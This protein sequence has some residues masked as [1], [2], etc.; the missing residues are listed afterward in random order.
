MADDEPS[1][2]AAG[3][4]PVEGHVPGHLL[5]LLG[6]RRIDDPDFGPSLEMALRDEVTNPHGSLH[7]G[8]MGVLI[9]C[10][11]AGI[12]V[13]AIGSQNIVATD[14]V[15]RF[16]TTV[17]VGPARVVGRPLRVG[18]RGAV[19]A[20]EVIDLGA[21]RRVVAAATLEYARLDAPPAA[22]ET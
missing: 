6:M 16:L 15:I 3:G 9:E 18:R 1:G 5:T 21:D 4:T 2:D 17:R 7:G 10:G 22:V 20:V 8:L 12:A 13:D 11:A 19:V 14:M